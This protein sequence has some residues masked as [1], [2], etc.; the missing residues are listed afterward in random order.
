MAN[1]RCI[2][3][4]ISTS[5]KLT[6]LYQ[7]CGGDGTTLYTWMIPHTDDWG[8]MPGDPF[9]VKHS[10]IPTLSI[11]EDG[12]KQILFEMARLK[13][14]IL[15]S[16]D[17][18]EYLQ[19]KNFENHQAGLHKRTPSKIPKYGEK[20]TILRELPGITA[21]I[22]LNLSEG[23]RREL[24][25]REENK[26]LSSGF[27]KPDTSLSSEALEVCKLLKT[28]I[29]MFRAAAKV[30]RSFSGKTGW[31]KDARLMLEADKREP[32]EV[33][34]VIRWVTRDSFWQSNILSMKKFREKY[35]TLYLQMNGQERKK[36]DAR[37]K[38]TRSPRADESDE[39]RQRGAK[40]ESSAREGIDDIIVPEL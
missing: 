16:K 3:K 20:G 23:K 13:L 12:V 27:S 11:S 9:T 1:K 14:I 40:T 30:P 21:P 25:R 19:I 26:D 5:R 28:E 39:D 6:E 36:D 29:L 7:T 33:F 24:K 32:E 17:G 18:K 31:G 35:D 4:S 8:R 22:E 37:S 15:Y 10:V 34:R 2:S 38:R